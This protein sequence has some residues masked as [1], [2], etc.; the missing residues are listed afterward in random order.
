MKKVRCMYK[1]SG[2]IGITISKVYDVVDYYP[3]HIL[4]G[5]MNIPL[6]KIINDD[7]KEKEYLVK[8]ITSNFILTNVFED[9]SIEY[10]RNEVINEILK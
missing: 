3:D 5:V 1:H 9:V 2:I 8:V 4:T 7:N 6:I 10:N